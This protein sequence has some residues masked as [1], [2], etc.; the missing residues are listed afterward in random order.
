MNRHKEDIITFLVVLATTLFFVFTPGRESLGSAIQG[1]IIALIFFGLL[2]LGYHFLVLKKK[3]VEF[4]LEEGAWR[5]QIIV[6]IPVVALA[7]LLTIL[8]FQF[9]P[10]FQKNFFLPTRVT[11][12]FGWFVGYELIL[13]PI[14]ALLYEIFFRGFVQKSWLEKRLGGFA[15]LAQSALFMIFL[16]VTASFGWATFP[17]ILFSFFA[18]FLMWQNNSL[19]QTWLASWFYLLL[20]DVFLL[21]MH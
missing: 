17:L 7:L 9:F 11:G 13:V 19:I 20:F 1:F 4:G 18:G 8:A 16:L 21:I 12:S 2:P 5:Y 3:R 10:D 6:M 15:I 14:L